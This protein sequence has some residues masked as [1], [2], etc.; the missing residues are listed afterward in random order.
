MFD[1]LTG[2]CL[3]AN[4]N[5][6]DST[7]IKSM[8]S[9]IGSHIRL[10]ALTVAFQAR[11]K[12][13]A[14]KDVTLEVQSGEFLC[15]LGTTGCGKSTILNAI[16]GFIKATSGKILVDRQEVI[17]PS[18]LRGMVF[19]QHAL[20]PWAT[21]LGN[22]EFG[23][24]SLGIS[25]RESKIIA[26]KLVDRIGLHAFSSAYPDELSGGMQQRVGLARALANDPALL[27]MDEPFGSLDAQTRISMQELLLDVWSGSGKTVIFV[28]HDVDE[29]I[30]LADRIVVL[31]A[32]P[33]QVKAE[34]VV[35]LPRPRQYEILASEEYMV[36]KREVIS[37]I[38]EETMKALSESMHAPILGKT[39]R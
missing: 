11:E 9:S 22:I 27:L 12:L 13:V 5:S 26:Q 29:A 37:A 20:F 35:S 36:T 19:Q 14:I 38:R 32:R 4:C 23:P 28:T 24:K 16:A 18:P 30:F 33:G 8:T 15:V 39:T 1:L 25:N 10:E 2:F 3:G 31:T 34:F 21:V 6:K 7:A 17:G